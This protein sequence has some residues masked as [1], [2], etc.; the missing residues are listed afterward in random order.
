MPMW[1]RATK[2]ALLFP[3][4]SRTRKVRN[5]S[6]TPVATAM[7]HDAR[8]GLSVRGVMIRGRVEVVAGLEA[9]RLNRSIHIRYMT[10]HGLRQPAI[11]NVLQGD[12]VTL[13]L[14]MEDVVTWTVTAGHRPD[15]TWSRPLA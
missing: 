9:R 4:S 14:L 5:L 10:A 13:R 11:A 7:I 12:D 2:S 6:H 3:T 15:P 8:D 1:Y